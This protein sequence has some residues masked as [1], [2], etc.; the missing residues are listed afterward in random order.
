M[1]T[2]H[3]K[4]SPPPL[5]FNRKLGLQHWAVKLL[6]AKDINDLCNEEFPKFIWE[7]CE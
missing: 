5:S 7:G 4:S 3:K 6:E 2:H 1:P